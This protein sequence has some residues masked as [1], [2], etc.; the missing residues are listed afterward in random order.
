MILGLGLDIVKISRIEKIYDK[1]GEGFL[2]KIFT[3]NEII[4][5]NSFSSQV[6]KREFLAKRFAAKEAF[7]KALGIG[8]G[9]IKFNEIE[10]YNDQNGKPEI[11][12]TKKIDQLI[13]ELFT[14]K[15]YQINISITDDAGIAQAIVILSKLI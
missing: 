7:A 12:R 2:E 11:L 4:K 10:I 3:K 1:F 13:K 9:R 6:K 15:D 5:V 14:V 8:I